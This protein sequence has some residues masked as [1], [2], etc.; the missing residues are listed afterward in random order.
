MARPILTGAP[1]LEFGFIDRPVEFYHAFSGRIFFN[2]LRDGA[3]I[4]L[5]RVYLSQ[6]RMVRLPP[7]PPPPHVHLCSFSGLRNFFLAV[8][9]GFVVS[10]FECSG[11]TLTVALF[12]YMVPGPTS[13]RRSFDNLKACSGGACSVM[14]LAVFSNRW[15]GDFSRVYFSPLAPI[16]SKRDRRGGVISR[17]HEQLPAEAKPGARLLAGPVFFGADDAARSLSPSIFSGQILPT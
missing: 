1:R 5:C 2:R 3:T 6:R 17:A 13:S 7:P 4:R 9:C 10:V 16:S 12:P 14:C 8:F 11:G 15:S